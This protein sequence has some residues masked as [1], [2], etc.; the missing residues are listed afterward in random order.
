MC[1]SNYYI[2]RASLVFSVRYFTNKL[3]HLQTQ[4]KTFE[5]AFQFLVEVQK[6]EFLMRNIIHILFCQL[7]KTS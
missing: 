3:T 1:A 2:L 7:L 6:D 4:A 5:L